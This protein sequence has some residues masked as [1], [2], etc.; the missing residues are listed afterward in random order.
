MV[1]KVVNS[2]NNSG[3]KYEVTEES[4]DGYEVVNETGG[5]FEIINDSGD[6]READKGTGGKREIN[7]E[8][9]GKFDADKE[10]SDDIEK[11]T[12]K[13]IIF[14]SLLG[15]LAF[16]I[17]LIAIFSSGGS[18][19][20]E[21]NGGNRYVISEEPVV[22]EDDYIDLNQN[23]TDYNKGGSDQT[24]VIDDDYNDLD[25]NY[26]NYDEGGAN[27]TNVTR[28]I[29]NG[30][31][32]SDEFLSNGNSIVITNNNMS[33]TSN[34]YVKYVYNNN[35]YTKL[36]VKNAF[37]VIVCDTASQITIMA[38]ESVRPEVVVNREG[39]LIIRNKSSNMNGVPKV[40]LPYNP[41]LTSVLLSGASS[42]SSHH[43]LEGDRVKLDLSGSSSFYCDIHSAD[44]DIQL[45]GTASVVSNVFAT[46][47]HIDMGGSSTASLTGQVL[48]LKLDLGGSSNMNSKAVANRY[49]F[50]CDNC[51]GSMSG[52]SAAYIHC[53]RN[54]NVNLS[55]ASSLHYSGDA[56]TSGSSTSS[57]SSIIHH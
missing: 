24:V 17:M 20:N 21:Y 54:I 51:N 53:D 55:G 47:F 32:V 31:D 48:S 8:I 45:T 7:D 44:I 29:I 46:E 36:E 49:S 23:H 15:V 22:I 2:T 10:R 57:A 27:Q 3:G 35:N 50:V 56:I 40:T 19:S 12:N 11:S 1:Y 41:Y 52:Y 38:D 33:F 4:G 39:K 42:F 5:K 13:K 18:N 25:N 26:T 30:E 14:L 16:I 28:I 34:N 43:A 37:E 6:K 9:S